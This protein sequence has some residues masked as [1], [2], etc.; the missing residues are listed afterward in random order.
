MS[1]MTECPRCGKK[2]PTTVLEHLDNGN[3]ACP[4]CVR[5]DDEKRDAD[6]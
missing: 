1:D 3:T 2:F 6:K 5:E 4:D